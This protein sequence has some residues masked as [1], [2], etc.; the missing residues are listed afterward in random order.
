MPNYGTRNCEAMHLRHRTHPQ[1][2]KTVNPGFSTRH[3][4]RLRHLLLPTDLSPS[5]IPTLHCQ[6]PLHT[7][8]D[9]RTSIFTM[10]ENQST[11]FNRGARPKSA[12]PAP[13]LQ[14][15]NSQDA[16]SPP[17]EQ[18]RKRPQS[19]Q[20]YSDEYTKA[21][22]GDR[23][24]S[25]HHLQRGYPA[26]RSVSPSASRGTATKTKP[27]PKPLARSQSVADI[28]RNSPLI[29]IPY[30][31]AHDE[32]VVD[33]GVHVTEEVVDEYQRTAGDVGMTPVG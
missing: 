27:V 24:I 9:F 6:S 18:P 7:C 21:V 13:T 29:D 22:Y 15:R 12:S 31:F 10:T 14:R 5:L 16:Q 19:A 20:D 30:R 33:R 8:L 3:Y 1:I 2:R 28:E 23:G 32:P 17:T 26:F 4:L 25:P 11:S